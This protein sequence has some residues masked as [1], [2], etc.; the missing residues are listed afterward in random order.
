MEILGTRID[1]STHD[2]RIASLRTWLH[3]EEGHL[4]VTPNPEMVLYAE[5]HTWFQQLINSA[6]LTIPDGVG[7]RFAAA[8]I[9]ES[10]GERTT[11]V[12]MLLDLAQLCEE[13]GKS[14]LLFGGKPHSA[15]K[16]VRYFRKIFPELQV[17][18]LAPEGIHINESSG[19][20]LSGEEIF[21]AIEGD[22][23]TV[24][25][26][27]LGA[28]KQEVFAKKALERIPT[29]RVAIGIGGAFEMFAG[30]LPRAPKWMRHLGF[31]WVW[32][33]V[34][35]PRRFVRIFRAVIIFPLRVIWDR[36]KHRTLFQAFF[37]V[38]RDLIR[39]FF[40]V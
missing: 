15:E 17:T 31:E 25:A 28:G 7:L 8:A 37:R 35:E 12:D 3:G 4:V 23:P 2:K 38:I 5:T 40:S 39:H 18:H 21:A 10:I 33:L 34:Q 6:D 24:L 26:C 14:L 29:L 32:R 9:G 19:E 16:T 27:A 1:V 30:T 36:L 22:K 13:E 20:L 11:G